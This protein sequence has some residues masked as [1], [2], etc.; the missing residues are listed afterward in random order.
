MGFDVATL[1]VCDSIIPLLT[2]QTDEFEPHHENLWE[3]ADGQ[4]LTENFD[5]DFYSSDFLNVFF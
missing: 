5:S 3:Y 4:T 2:L 1:A